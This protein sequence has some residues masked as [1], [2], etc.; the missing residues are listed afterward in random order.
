M[1]TAV[2]ALLDPALDCHAIEPLGPAPDPFPWQTATVPAPVQA[3][4]DAAGAPLEEAV[5]SSLDDEAR[6]VLL[7]LAESKREGGRLLTA[8]A[9]LGIG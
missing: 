5:W 7:K 8:L 3:R 1:D 4:L 9:E 6:Y 2:L